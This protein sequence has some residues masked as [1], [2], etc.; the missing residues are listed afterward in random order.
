MKDFILG[1]Q[2]DSNDALILAVAPSRRTV[3][4]AAGLA[5]LGRILERV[6]RAQG[7]QIRAKRGREAPQRAR[8]ASGRP[9][10]CREEPYRALLATSLT[11]V[12]YNFARLA[13]RALYA[14][15]GLAL[16]LKLV[17]GP[18]V[19]IR[20]IRDGRGRSKRPVFSCGTFNARRCAGR[21]VLKGPG[22]AGNSAH[23]VVDVSVAVMSFSAR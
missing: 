10:Y 18:H 2:V 5:V 11:W 3:P 8:L 21:V 22:G 14:G 20:T 1:T 12:A 13:R 19:A 4:L 17:V 16:A 15:I 9:T 7:A 6:R 23:L